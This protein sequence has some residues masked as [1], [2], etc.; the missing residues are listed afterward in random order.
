MKV[1]QSIYDGP[2]SRI[3]VDNF[4]S[5]NITVGVSVGVHQGSI[6]SPL[7]LI[8]VLEALSREFHIG[9][10]WDIFMQTTWSSL[11]NLLII[12]DRGFLL[13]SRISRLRASG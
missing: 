6:L 11:L 10:P 4:Y 5:E 12:F 1:V 13:G 3:R 8:I 9:C 2:Q 7:L